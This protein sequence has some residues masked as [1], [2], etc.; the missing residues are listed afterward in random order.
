MLPSYEMGHCSKVQGQ[1]KQ[2]VPPV[3]LG[4]NNSTEHFKRFFWADLRLRDGA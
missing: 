4:L 2:I 1:H 3:E